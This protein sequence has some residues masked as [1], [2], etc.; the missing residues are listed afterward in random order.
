MRYRVS[1]G[2]TAYYFDE[3]GVAAISNAVLTS[4]TKT[5]QYVGTGKGDDGGQ[6]VATMRP[7]PAD[8]ADA[9][10]AVDAVSEEWVSAMLLKTKLYDEKKP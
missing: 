1:I 2:G 4:L 6:Y 3:A 10:V 9:A 5:D 7:V 8:A